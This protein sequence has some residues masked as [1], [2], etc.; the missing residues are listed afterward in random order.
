MQQCDVA[1]AGAGAS[2]L[3]CAIRA[4]TRGRKVLVVD[5][6]DVPGRKIRV[7]GGGRCNFTNL[8][9]AAA[10]YVSRNPH[11]VKS[12]LAR[13][14][15][16]DCV[17]F[18]EGMGL[19]WVDEGE[20]RLFCAQGG[21]AVA[22]SLWKQAEEAGASFLLGQE[23][24]AAKKT[25]RG[26]HLFLEDDCIACSSLAVAAGG[27]AWPQIGASSLGHRLA[28]ELGLRVTPVLPGLVPLLARADMLELCRTLSG[29]SLPVRITGE[30]VSAEGDLLFTHRGI[31]G[32][33]VLDVSVFW[34]LNETLRIDLLPGK[35]LAAVLA[36]SPKLEIKN[37][38]ARL[39]PR[40]LADELC[41]R[42]GWRGRAADAPKKLFLEMEQTLHAWPYT[43]S[44]P[45]GFSKAEAALGGVD[46]D[47]FSSKTMECKDIPGLYYTG[48]ALDVTGRLGGFNLHWAW[49]S[50]WAAGEWA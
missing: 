11:F 9:L 26:F 19:G 37:L 32:L 18:F 8:N 7:A 38:L 25:G 33:V 10:D 34:R 41:K 6:N 36:E 27:P 45:D 48:E 17:A 30:R 29:V 14:G 21:D 3:F 15:P 50:G 42:N 46:T 35:D 12:A 5:H 31:S 28:R 40:R 49:A 22:D 16:W 2:G 23:I 44:G 47:H 13:F 1:I 24:V 39:M 20:G 43:P 4:A